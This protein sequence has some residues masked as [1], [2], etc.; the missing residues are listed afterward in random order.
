MKKL[1]FVRKKALP[2]FLVTVLASSSLLGTIKVEANSQN[3]ALN[4]VV[5]AISSEKNHPVTNIT[6]GD[7]ETYWES[8]D[9]W[10]R[11]IELDLDGIYTL[12]DIIVHTPV[13][14]VS[15][16][17]VYI[18]EDNDNYTKVA[19]KVDD[20]VET[21]A[22]TSFK[23]NG[24]ACK[25]RVSI[26]YSSLADSTKGN[27]SQV[28]YI[29]EIEIHGTKVNGTTTPEAP[30]IEI[31]DFDESEYGKRYAKMESDEEY[32]N[33]TT[34][35]EMINL[36][37]RVAGEKYV[38][39]F[40]FVLKESST[41]KDQFAI[42]QKEG[43]I[44]ITGPNGIS[45]ASGFNYYLK[46]YAHVN[47]DPIQGEKDIEMPEQLP[48]VESRVVKETPYDYKYLNNFCTPSYTYAFWNWDEYEPYLDWCAMNGVNLMLDFIGQE[49]VQ[50]KMLKEFG[51]TD[52]EILNYIPGPAYY[53]WFYMG[54]M[55]SFGGPLPTDWFEQRTELGRKVHERMYVFGIDPVFVGYAGQVPVDF[56]EKNP[57]AE[58]IDQ[59]YW[60]GGNA[61]VRPPV[62]KT[63]VEGDEVDYFD[64]VATAFYKASEETF[65]NIT[66]YFA[67]DPFHEGGKKTWVDENGQT[68]TL[69]EAKI[70]SAV[71][72]KMLEYNPD[73]QWIVQNWQNNPTQS[74]LN[75]VDKEHTIVLDLY[76]DNQP[77]YQ[78]TLNGSP[79][80]DYMVNDYDGTSWIWGMLHSFG[81]RMGFSG[82]PEILTEEMPN[83][84]DSNYMVGIG[85]TAESVGTNPM[86]YELIYDM[87]WENGPIDLDEYISDYFLSRYGVRSEN[88]E[89]AWTIMRETAYHKR[90]DR[91]RAE[92]S[93]INA[94]PSLDATTASGYITAVIDYDKEEFE[95]ILEL[96]L[97]EYD[98]L[99]NSDA[100]LYDLADITRQVLQNSSYEY[101]Q[102]AK[103]AWNNKDAASF[104]LYSDKFL[105]IILLQDQ[106]LSTTDEFSL[107]HWIE[108]SRTMLDDAD[109]WTKDL[110][111]ANARLQVT[112][113]GS[114]PANGMLKDYSNRQW[115]GL[116]GDY[117]Y[118]RWSQY[119]EKLNE[120]AQ[121]GTW[122]KNVGINWFSYTYR[123]ANLKENVDSEGNPYLTAK[124]E[125]LNI[126]ELAQK[127]LD[128]YSV[129]NIEAEP[130]SQKENI[131]LSKP[132]NATGTIIK[133]YPAENLTDGDK[134]TLWMNE[135][136]TNASVTVD[137][138]Q[139]VSADGIEIEFKT[140]EEDRRDA[141]TYAY[142]VE[143]LDDKGVWI[144]VDDK[145]EDIS[146]K[147]TIIP[148]AYNGYLKQVKVTILDAD[149]EQYDFKPCLAEI[150]VFKG[151][152]EG[153]A[154]AKNIAL[155]KNVTAQRTAP[156]PER[157]ASK[158]VDGNTNTIWASGSP[159]TS[160]I[161]VDLGKMESIDGV[162]I[163][164]EKGKTPKFGYKIELL[165]ENQKVLDMI[166]KLDDHSS[167][168]N[169]FEEAIVGKA[170]SVRVTLNKPSD[171]TAFPALAELEVYQ[172]D[173]G[174][175][176]DYYIGQRYGIN[177]SAQS[178][179]NTAANAM[180]G[181]KET[182]WGSGSPS[183]P[184]YLEYN[185]GT[186]ISMDQIELVFPDNLMNRLQWR[187]EFYDVIGNKID[188]LGKND[189]IE[190]AEL[191][192]GDTS[193]NTAYHRIVID[194]GKNAAKVK[195]NVL[196]V[197][198]ENDSAWAGIAE[199]N[200]FHI[201]KDLL[202]EKE[203]TAY[204]NNQ[205]TD[206]SALVDSN[207]ESLISI[208]GKNKSL[209]VDLETV[210]DIEKMTLLHSNE[211][212]LL[213]SIYGSENGQEY[214][215][216]A[217]R[218]H[219]QELNNTILETFGNEFSCRYLRIEFYNEDDIQLN[220]LYVYRKD[221]SKRFKEIIEKYSTIFSK[222]ER[223]QGAG[224][225]PEEIYD[226]VMNDFENGAKDEQN[227]S[228]ISKLTEFEQKLS[229]Y[230]ELL[231]TSKVYP[232]NDI[233]LNE[234]YESELLLNYL[235]ENE[236]NEATALK[237]AIDHAREV[238][239]KYKVTQTEIDE[240]YESLNTVYNTVLNR[241]SL[242]EQYESLI[243][244][245]KSMIEQT[246]VGDF[247]GNVSQET[248]DDFKKQIVEIQDKYSP[249]SSDEE[250]STYIKQIQKAIDEFNGKK[251]V[252]DTT[253]LELL[254]VKVDSLI[255]EDY[256]VKQWESL[257]MLY[258]QA[259][260]LLAEE[261]IGYSELKELTELLQ[262]Q[263]DQLKPIDKSELLNLGNIIQNL[264]EV[265]Y[266]EK[267]WNLIVNYQIAIADM[268]DSQVQDQDEVDNF[269]QKVENVLALKKANYS[270]VENA[271]AK[272][273]SLDR[274]KYKDFS[275]VD[276]AIQGV[277]Y[278]KYITQQA[279]VDEMALSIEK[280]IDRLELID[281]STVPDD[282]DSNQNGEGNQVDEGIDKT[283]TGQSNQ[284]NSYLLLSSF[285]GF[286]LVIIA[287]L[288][289]KQ[290]KK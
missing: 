255:K 22:G 206:I 70:S 193:N 220:E 120:S 116:T 283:N 134:N 67:I 171:E 14:H 41:G 20:V 18:S 275:K 127:A 104:K 64:K 28:G 151:N 209:T 69:D 218:S 62:L 10:N 85:V 183:F 25:V 160:W 158:A 222:Y 281:E 103:K 96:Y 162:G 141:P 35:T 270:K 256:G 108:M 264:N 111:E 242:K 180:D 72:K 261:Q 52:E 194:Y 219:D 249:E 177:Y 231:Q 149:M 169:H 211:E 144:T 268:L 185:V 4:K 95:K 226:R 225:I 79:K 155:N 47:Y 126:N 33:Q 207:E 230:A 89:K 289:H 168:T 73:A 49:E 6:D 132:V 3:V 8:G 75:G 74:F 159:E 43:K 271:I 199:F 118:G 279:E 55:S 182:R 32:K 166:D 172:K 153:L 123:W 71:Q 170:Q 257:I 179:V 284:I 93:I 267:E 174:I 184:Q 83:Q 263:V 42:E 51:Y 201:S 250:I 248:M 200:V 2:A 129:T 81:G 125:T 16:Y 7:L 266:Y 87:G 122:N 197:E 196:G 286:I 216:I 262:N 205:V 215:L 142:K 117:Y 140:P 53:G 178:S 272:A 217:D 136:F 156:N 278:G 88:I 288:K 48:K 44:E 203:R 56:E 135:D 15:N 145:S 113:W 50:R 119:F 214:K 150:R 260:A 246:N 109:D 61:F 19:S 26:T 9:D 290:I 90:Y 105:N 107:G 60:P 204:V 273:K 253:D 133:G 244:L 57:D 210:A 21:E 138:G 164:F 167:K 277:I 92:D 37:A 27:S 192:Q 1:Y 234:I 46:N 66:P 274:G 229:Q 228:S 152:G 154:S 239:N 11:W 36:V 224:Q 131:A 112:S 191:I 276:E 251:V 254:I 29:N 65:G 77:H 94:Q 232:N 115:S 63:Y 163:T 195:F 259:K 84:L 97:E 86:L 280:A 269:I 189:L 34:V 236:L 237:E 157:V 282:N 245:A 102:E 68:H 165:D 212:P 247:E 24:K 98:N 39:D 258:D 12:T 287:R 124:D 40:S 235:A 23:V 139:V 252:I 173:N 58:V 187:L 137:F 106:V 45:L 238:Y 100:Y 243:Y 121:A 265:D 143:V 208:G 110:F 17:N 241:L 101:L 285:V 76:A 30:E 161:M 78:D 54:N 223:G 227:Y 176:E 188:Q 146:Q 91:Q 240:A 147:D 80:P 99:K 233:L 198:N 128:L 186:S 181:K 82:M 148:V 221:Y 38:D 175:E 213:Y 13:G 5:T 202:R 190:Q 31:V 59:G 130:E 114:G